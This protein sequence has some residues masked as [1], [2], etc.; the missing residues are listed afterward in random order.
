MQFIAQDR[1]AVPDDASA[2]QRSLQQQ[3]LAEMRTGSQS[4]SSLA[5]TLGLPMDHDELSETDSFLIESLQDPRVAP[6]S[7]N[8]GVLLRI[9]LCE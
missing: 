1:H 6:H 9:V 3:L 5:Q 2:E 7:M 4:A 8:T